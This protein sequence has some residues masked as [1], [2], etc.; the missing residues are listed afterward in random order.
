[1]VFLCCDSI[2]NKN[3][4]A[5]VGCLPLAIICI[6]SKMELGRNSSATQLS[7]QMTWACSQ[8]LAGVIQAL[9]LF[10]GQGISAGPAPIL[11]KFWSNN[12]RRLTPELF[13]RLGFHSS[14]YGSLQHRMIRL[15]YRLWVRSHTVPLRLLTLLRYPF[16]VGDTYLAPFFF[17]CFVPA[18]WG[19]V[20]LGGMLKEYGNCVR[21]Y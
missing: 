8:P 15:M 3:S 5:L 13:R 16:A 7:V 19:L 4:I 17:L 9:G 11:Q 14:V 18:I 12:N 2:S 10:H 1:M 21:V 20:I 6:I